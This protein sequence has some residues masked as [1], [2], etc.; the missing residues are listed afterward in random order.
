M[1]KIDLKTLVLK[2]GNHQSPEAGM[3]VME[4]VAYVAGEPHS[5]HPQCA[6]PVITKFLI[7]WNDALETDEDRVRLLRD[8]VPMIVGTRSRAVEARRSKMAHDWFCRVFT[9][10]WLDLAGLHEHAT[11]VR[12]NPC[13]EVLQAAQSAAEKSESA[14]RSAAE[15]AARSA[16]ESA[17]RSAAWSAAESAARSAA[18]SAARS[19]A[20]SAA[21]S[22]AESA[23]RSAARS[24][25]WSAAE[26]A[27]ESA[28]WSAARSAALVILSPAVQR[29]QTSAVEL[30]RAMIAVTEEA[31]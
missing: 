7:N 29:L 20:R 13:L 28:A 25:A 4:A 18:W 16:A 15:S 11:L 24:A 14:A 5:D 26:S 3:C 2:K 23:A 10:E 9:A 30:V 27:A 17:A 8:L 6:C 21:E 1:E 31:A 12:E 19:A 22:A